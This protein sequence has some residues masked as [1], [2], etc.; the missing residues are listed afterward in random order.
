[1]II[2][3]TKNLKLNTTVISIGKFDCFHKGHQ[4]ILKEAASLKNDDMMQ[5]IFTFDKNPA[6]Y[7]KNH[8]SGRIF[9]SEE[10]RN[11]VMGFDADYYIEYPFDDMIK[12]MR[13]EEFVKDILVDKLGMKVIVSG[14]DFRFG[15]NR[16]GDVETL[17]RLGEKYGYDV[18]VV[19]SVFYK[20]RKISS[21]LIRDELE[22]GNLDD[23]SAM[24][25]RTFY[26]EDIVRSGAH[27]GRSMGLPTI[28]FHVPS[29]KLLPPMGVYITKTCIDGIEYESIT[30]IG[31]R[32]TFYDNGEKFVE[33]YIFD[34]NKD[35]Y[36][37]SAKVLFYKFIRPERKFESTNALCDEINKNIEEAQNYFKASA[38]SAD[39]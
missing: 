13:P 11:L 20:G 31:T 38:I 6:D 28:N 35:V 32:P 27:I 1:M 17:K 36:K 8:V 12:N 26:M 3:T 33:T 4:E 25:G 7:A 24:L 5:V 18:S 10:R 15:K 21:S 30:N 14:D 34:F 16:E 23:V 39:K 9:S 22:K 19:N 29:D 37:K 2:C